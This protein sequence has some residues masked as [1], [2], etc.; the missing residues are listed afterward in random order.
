MLEIVIN[1]NKLPHGAVRSVRLAIAWIDVQDLEG[2]THIELVDKVP[3]PTDS[4]PQDIKSAFDEGY[5]L[6]GVYHRG[7]K[8]T[9]PYITLHIRDIYRGLPRIFWWTTAPN[10]LIS[11]TLAHEVGHHVSGKSCYANTSSGRR[12][13]A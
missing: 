6:Y 8:S 2:L 11:Y 10:L 5:G 7:S 9:S 4:A 13:L 1:A 3:K 12:K